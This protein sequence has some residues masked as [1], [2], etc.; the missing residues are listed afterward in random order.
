M[1][2]DNDISFFI[3]LAKLNLHKK[4]KSFNISNINLWKMKK[5]TNKKSNRSKKIGFNYKINL[6]KRRIKDFTNANYILSTIIFIYQFF[7]YITE[8]EHNN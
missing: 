5:M 8:I 4:Y 6:L 2:K 3:F 7:E 1:S